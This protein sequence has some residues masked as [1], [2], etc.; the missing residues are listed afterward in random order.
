[1]IRGI[2]APEAHT[3]VP[4]PGAGRGR[5]I[6]RLP[7]SSS[8]GALGPAVVLAATIAAAAVL[9]FWALGRQGFW[10]DEATTGWALRLNPF[11]VLGVLPHRETVPPLYYAIAW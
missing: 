6:P 3:P 5:L 9:R 7:L 4:R 8:G 2:R 11:E 1:T 10:Y